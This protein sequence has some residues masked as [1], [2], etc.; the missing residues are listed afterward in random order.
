MSLSWE[1]DENKPKEA[2]F[3]PYLKIVKKEEIQKWKR[4]QTDLGRG[5]RKKLT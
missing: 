5:S 1:K 4:K 3:G 2:R